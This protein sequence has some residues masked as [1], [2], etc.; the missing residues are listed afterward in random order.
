M[1][2][3]KSFVSKKQDEHLKECLISL[4]YFNQYKYYHSIQ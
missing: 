2:K 4:E 3:G 1:I